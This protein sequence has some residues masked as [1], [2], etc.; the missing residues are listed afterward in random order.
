MKILKLFPKID[1][2]L[3][4]MR[5]INYNIWYETPGDNLFLNDISLKEWDNIKNKYE[6]V[7]LLPPKNW[8]KFGNKIDLL[9]KIKETKINKI[10]FDGDSCYRSFEDDFYDGIDYIFYRNPDKNNNL[11]KIN[12]SWLPYS[13]DTNRY[14]PKFG[15]NGI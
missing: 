4:E 7:F 3:E 12:S 5:R 8:I 6:F 13:V 11:P 1:K 9:N 14:L 2:K 10:L 15:G